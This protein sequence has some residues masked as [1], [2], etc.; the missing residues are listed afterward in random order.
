L[1]DRHSPV[2]RVGSAADV[3]G[4]LGSRQLNRTK[5]SLKPTFSSPKSAQ[6]QSFV[7]HTFRR[8]TSLV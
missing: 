3:C 4:G 1:T 5:Q 7:R 2:I 8:S 6:V